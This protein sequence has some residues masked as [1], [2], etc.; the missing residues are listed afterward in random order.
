MFGSWEAARTGGV[1]GQGAIVVGIDGLTK[2]DGTV[3]ECG[4]LDGTSFLYWTSNLADLLCDSR[5]LSWALRRGD[6][7]LERVGLYISRRRSLTSWV[8]PTIIL[9]FSHSSLGL[10]GANQRG[11]DI[12]SADMQSKRKEKDSGRTRL[13]IR[14]FR[15]ISI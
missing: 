9:P 14:Y 10:T 2:D 7:V 11:H 15:Y 6:K 8:I 4:R 1:L 3:E 5:H 12:R 13:L